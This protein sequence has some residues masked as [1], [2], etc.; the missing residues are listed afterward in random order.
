MH[1]CLSV[2]VYVYV[3]FY[4]HVHVVTDVRADTRLRS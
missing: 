4:L 1:A 2:C 3:C